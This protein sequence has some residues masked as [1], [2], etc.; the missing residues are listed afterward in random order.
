MAQTARQIELTE[1]EIKETEERALP[2][3]AVVFETIRREG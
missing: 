3:A 1:E 2:R